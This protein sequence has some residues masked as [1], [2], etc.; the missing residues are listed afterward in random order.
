MESGLFEDENIALFFPSHKCIF[1]TY[2]YSI[3]LICIFEQSDVIKNKNEVKVDI[4]ENKRGVYIKM[5]HFILNT[6]SV[7]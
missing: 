1:Y 3:S 4:H 7:S 2:F 5:K 6:L